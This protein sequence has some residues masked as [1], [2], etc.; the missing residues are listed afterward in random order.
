MTD[1]LLRILIKFVHTLSLTDRSDLKLETETTLGEIGLDSIAVTETKN[2]LEQQFN[3]FMDAK[4]VLNLR[5]NDLW[6]IE[7]GK[8]SSKSF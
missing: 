6:R 8:I 7:S 3:L 5:V 4:E 1:F 2:I